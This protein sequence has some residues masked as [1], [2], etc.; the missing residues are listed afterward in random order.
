MNYKCHWTFHF[1]KIKENKQKQEEER[2]RMRIEEEKLEKR[3]AEQRA[4][5]QQEYME[6]HKKQKRA[7]VRCSSVW[8][9]VLPKSFLAAE[10]LRICVLY[11]LQTCLE[12]P[13]ELHEPKTKHQEEEKRARQ[14]QEIK[15][16]VPQSTEVREEKR[17]RLNHEVQW[18]IIG[19]AVTNFTENL[20]SPQIMWLFS[21]FYLQR[22][23]FPPSP[24]LRRKQTNPI[25]PRPSTVMS[26]LTHR[27]VSHLVLNSCKY[28]HIEAVMI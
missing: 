19:S 7:K 13:T 8:W 28:F 22:A 9:R 17:E 25:T 1:Q 4:R 6:E 27:T 5:M 2:E 16:K 10:Q 23:E 12:T 3:V 24:T 20:N 21:L 18:K 14:H 26:Q 11:C 15:K